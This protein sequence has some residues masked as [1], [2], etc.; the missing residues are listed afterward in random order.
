MGYTLK[1]LPFIIP[2]NFTIRGHLDLTMESVSVAKNV[3]LHVAELTLE[4]S[5]IT[6]T[7]METRK[8]IPI[9]K[10]AYDADREFYIAHLSQT[11][12]PGKK[13][14][15][16]IDFLA[17]LNDNLKGFYRSVYKD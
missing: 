14:Q 1:L 15:I 8:T 3:T 17:I 12:V 2:D 13:Y 10:H 6:L 4:E 9:E 5:T 16:S 7:D 11:L